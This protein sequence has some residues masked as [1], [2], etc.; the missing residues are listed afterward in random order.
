MLLFLL[1][2]ISESKGAA[3]AHPQRDVGRKAARPICVPHKL[4]LAAI[5]STPVAPARCS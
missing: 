4:G 5:Y 1:T 3:D 2:R